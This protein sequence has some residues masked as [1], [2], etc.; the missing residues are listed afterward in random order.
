MSSGPPTPDS[1]GSPKLGSVGAFKTVEGKKAARAPAADNAAA[2]AAAIAAKN[3]AN[4]KSIACL[5][6]AVPIED[7]AAV[8]YPEGVS[9]PSSELVQKPKKFKY[10][11]SFLMQ[12]APVVTFKPSED[13]DQVV[14]N[15]IGD[16]D[17]RRSSANRSNSGIGRQ[18]RN[19]SDSMGFNGGLMGQLG[20]GANLGS[21]E[22]RFAISNMRMQ[23]GT[24]GAD[25]NSN[26][27]SM[28]S[29][30]QQYRP[31][32]SSQISS[33]ISQM[34]PSSMKGGR[35]SMR[36][37]RPGPGDRVPSRGEYGSGRGMAPASASTLPEEKVEP[38]T[39]SSNRWKPRRP[40]PKVAENSD[41][42]APDVVQ[43]KV[44]G[45]L[46]KMTLEKFDKISDQILEIVAQSKYETDGRTLR[47]V[48][49]LTFDKATDEAHWSNMYAR[50]CKKVLHSIDPDITEEGVVDRTG[51]PIRGGALFRKYLLTKCQEQFEKGWKV[52]PE[53]EADLMSEEY[54]KAATVKRRGLGLIRFIGEL[55]MLDMLSEKIMH[56]SIQGLITNSDSPAEEEL[57]SLCGLLRT[58]GAKIDVDR[59]RDYVDVYFTKLEEILASPKLTSR[60]KFMI[61]D[62]FDIRKSGWKTKAADKGPKTIAEIHQEAIAQR[63]TAA[64]E[65]R[66]AR[67]PP[68]RRP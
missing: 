25:M 11:L 49:A 39:L 17:E 64:R 15:T 28:Y 4:A 41:I 22:Q 56:Q 61:M 60:I 14:K 63:E 57:E 32:S 21:S 45:L 46:N 44:N 9:A 40:E 2:N 16:I 24:N 35:A 59:G 43:R 19:A 52:D 18:G 36:G 66:P 42:L 5:K 23:P 54:Y 53:A 12:F 68:R 29:K 58:V 65:A 30:M 10:D 62:V 67:G 34:P 55:Y 3:A 37:K 31:N 6:A 33:M 27:F 48:I 38:L 47:Q 1:V 8:V 26:A 20:A 13:W 51:T 50:F 7:I